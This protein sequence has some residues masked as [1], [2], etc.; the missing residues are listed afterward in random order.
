M[1]NKFIPIFFS[2]IFLTTFA[3]AVTGPLDIITKDLD[4]NITWLITTHPEEKSVLEKLGAPQLD[5]KE[6]IYYALND[7]KYS[8]CIKFSHHNVSYVSYQLPPES[9]LS[10]QDFTSSI[11]AS[12]VSLFPSS[13]HEKGRYLTF[14]LKKENL[15][16]IFTNNSEKKLTKIIYE[17][18]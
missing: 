10:I 6:K 3:A 7:Y 12:D 2:I 9:K 15:Q 16:L 8:L 17:K 18:K 14:F 4:K 1:V 13:G 11:K 5:E